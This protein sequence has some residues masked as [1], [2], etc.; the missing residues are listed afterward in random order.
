M[1]PTRSALR[2]SKQAAGSFLPSAMPASI[3]RNYSRELPGTAFLSVARAAFDGSVL[4][5]VVRISY[6]GVVSS[7]ML[8]IA[9][10]VLASMPALANILNFIWARAAHG[11]NKIRFSTGVQI[12]MITLLLGIALVPHTPLGLVMLS[13]VLLAVWVC[14]SG[15]IA[16]RSTIWRSNY[17]RHL[18]ARVAGKLATIQ[19]LTASTLGLTLGAVMGDHL[20]R[21][22]PGLSLESIGVEP[23]GVFR[24]YVVMCVAFGAVGVAILS[25]IRVRQHKRMLREERDSSSDNTGPT[26]NPMGVVR[27]LLEDRRFGVYQVNQFLMGMGNLMLMPLIPIILRERFDIDYFQGILLASALPMLITPMMIPVWSRLLDK[28]HIVKF[29]TVHSWVFV[30]TIVALFS[31]T[32][33]EQKWLLYVAAISQGSAQAGGMLAW[34]LGHHDFAPKERASEYM[35]VHVTLTGV[36]GLIGPVLAVTLYNSLEGVRDH[37]GVFVLT[38]CLGLVLAGAFGFLAMA[39]TMDLTPVNDEGPATS[40]TQGPAPVSKA[41]L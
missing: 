4:G 14:W 10:A 32:M 20:A 19:T 2:L 22:D 38:I 5:I 35:G 18:R 36:R 39:R 30:F 3:R 37:A 7:S 16:M 8:N 21:I 31:A 9:V 13:A 15:F 27:L 29:R 12:A 24:V 25:T 40:K 28:V 1:T 23:L 11:K 33:F 26:I 34:Q 6:D 17:P 41:G